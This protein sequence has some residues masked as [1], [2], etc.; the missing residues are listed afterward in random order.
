M[1]NYNYIIKIA[2][3]TYDTYY[4]KSEYV[5]VYPSAYRGQA[6]VSQTKNVPNQN[7]PINP[8]AIL[9]TEFNITNSNSAVGNNKK[10]FIIGG[11]TTETLENCRAKR[12]SFG[13]ND[14]WIYLIINGYLFLV[15]S[16]AYNELI[17]AVLNETDPITDATDITIINTKINNYYKKNKLYANI[18]LNDADLATEWAPNSNQTE[19]I[20]KTKI[21]QNIYSSSNTALDMKIPENTENNVYIFCGLSFTTSPQNT[22]TNSIISF[23][24][25]NCNAQYSI[26]TNNIDDESITSSKLWNDLINGSTATANNMK[27]TLSQDQNKPHK[28]NINIEGAH[29]DKALYLVNNNNEKY[30]VGNNISD[31]VYFNDGIP[32]VKDGDNDNLGTGTNPIYIS[33]GKLTA[34]AETVGGYDET[35][36]SYTPVNLASGEIVVATD[37]VGA[38]NKPIYMEDGK[39]KAISATVGA[40][41]QNAIV[42][43]YL[44]QGTITNIS[45][46]S[47]NLNKPVYIN[48]GTIKPISTNIA[49]PKLIKLNNGEITD[50]DNTS[51]YGSKIKPIYVSGGSIAVSDAGV[52]GTKQPVYMEAG[53]ITAGDQIYSKN[54][55]INN[56][57]VTNGTLA[58][59]SDEDLNIPLGNGLDYSSGIYLK[60]ASTSEVGGIKV[61]DTPSTATYYNEATI[62]LDKNNVAKCYYKDTTYDGT[63]NQIVINNETISLANDIKNIS[64]VTASDKITAGS[65]Y[66]NSDVRLKENIKP[67]E[68]RESILDL[69]IYNYDFKQ[70]A[71]NQIGCLAQDLQKLYPELVN[72]SASGYLSINES[73]L[74]YLLMEEVKQLKIEIEELKKKDRN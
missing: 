55:K 69:P 59:Y 74:I 38:N 45:A 31:I 30:T 58:R 66:A 64:T 71:K 46:N 68:Y 51:N 52:G 39:L 43:V 5:K 32:T 14:S 36:N 44:N 47:G 65:F 22:D 6:Q 72:E 12:V 73:K 15:H 18:S 49:E 29:V 63:T 61:G 20:A 62:Y 26:S 8:E 3:E 34:S 50:W 60:T 54:L 17:S 40:N 4:I 25:L 1:A 10:N 21:L 28:F 19:R 56:T 37:D 24:I 48:A 9:Y 23:D 42:P 70:G 41:D 67:F 7:Y 57:E 13:A 33:K 16:A 53:E 35:D 11:Y 27:V 2:G